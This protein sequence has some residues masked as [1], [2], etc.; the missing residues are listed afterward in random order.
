MALPGVGSGDGGFSDPPNIL[1]EVEQPIRSPIPYVPQTRVP[2]LVSQPLMAV[3]R[4]TEVK[5]IPDIPEHC[6]SDHSFYS[7]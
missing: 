4:L 1:R 7:L 2:V 6:S 3:F 5:D